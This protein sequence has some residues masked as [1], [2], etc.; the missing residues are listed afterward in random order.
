MSQT[1][2][3]PDIAQTGTM[4]PGSTHWPHMMKSARLG[5]VLGMPMMFMVIVFVMS[6]ALPA[7][8]QPTSIHLPQMEDL[9]ILMHQPQL[10]EFAQAIRSGASP[11]SP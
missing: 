8:S 4:P 10:A 11:P 9:R 7:Y 6:S 2:L 3:R 5:S 1:A